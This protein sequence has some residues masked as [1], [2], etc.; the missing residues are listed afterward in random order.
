MISQSVSEPWH[1]RIVSHVGGAPT[2]KK[3]GKDAGIASLF[4]IGGWLNS[5]DGP[6][7]DASPGTKR[8][9]NA[10]F[11]APML[12][13]LQGPELIK[14]WKAREVPDFVMHGLTTAIGVLGASTN[15]RDMINSAAML[16]TLFSMAGHLEDGVSA[17][18]LEGVEKLEGIVPAKARQ[19][20]SGAMVHVP[21]I[22]PGDMLHLKAGEVVPVDGVVTH[23][24]HHGVPSGMGSVT[25]PAVLSGEGNPVTVT[26]S[27]RLPQG[28]VVA[29]GH[30]VVMEAKALASDSVI[31]RNVQYIKDAEKV[32]GQT[33]HSIEHGIKK[34]YVPIMLAACAAEFAWS[35]YKHQKKH[36][37]DALLTDADDVKR[38]E[39]AEAL[40]DG[41]HDEAQEAEKKRP[42]TTVDH[43]RKSV[44]RTAELA[45]KMAPC[46]IMASMLVIPF[47][48][49]A[50]AAKHGVMVREDAALEKLKNVTH[51]LSDIRGTLT[52]GVSKFSGL[53]VWDETGKALQKIG[54]E[55]EVFMLGLMGK[56]QRGAQHEIATSVRA[57]A[58]A[59]G[60][61]LELAAGETAQ[62]IG[63]HGV[64]G[65][66]QDG[67]EI[68]MGGKRLF[69][70]S[71]HE[72]PEG[73]A[74]AVERFGGDTCFFRH[75]HEGVV[76]YGIADFLHELRPGVKEAVAALRRD[77]KKVVLVTGMPQ[78]TAESVLAKLDCGTMPH[79]PIELRAECMSLGGVGGRGKDDVVREFSARKKNVL[80]AIGDAEN[81]A[82][83]MMQVK[84]A[85]G[86]SM[87]VAS[88]GAAVTKDKASMVVEGVH[89]LPD[90]IALSRG[91]SHALWL[92]VGAAASWMTLLVGSHYAGYHMK[93]QEASVLHEVPTFLLTL[94]SL[95]QSLK[96][97][98]QLANVAR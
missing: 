93:A 65:S 79:N 27:E 31:S 87:A 53:N 51:V 98:H 84:N 94:A 86:V 26:L 29:P 25:F 68:V 5:E 39:K 22:K 63:A 11:G 2:V 18:S 14:T 20:G 72:L 23:I 61:T 3:I 80:A 46:A 89:Q 47:V 52:T 45:I 12:L 28:A 48:K 56:A 83:F 57:A 35:Y 44:K 40:L 41:G 60:H 13:K 37:K 36:A 95:G 9:V 75:E 70:E 4:A 10:A 71:G 88:T 74:A 21:D 30:E 62:A 16:A 24:E 96:L 67:H 59:K 1:R 17:K 34:I 90:L 8:L 54:A 66:L 64:R 19:H 91:L 42:R 33:A 50:L 85:G 15:D 38:W 69:K 43:V 55:G 82:P 78:R 58:A 77:G 32:Q 81:D 92:N 76:R 49:N 97:T 73:L 6:L 7:K